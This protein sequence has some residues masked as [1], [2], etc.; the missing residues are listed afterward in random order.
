M[1][2]MESMKKN[3][4]T[5]WVF[6]PVDVHELTGKLG[7]AVNFIKLFKTIQGK[8]FR[9]NGKRIAYRPNWC[10]LQLL[11]FDCGSLSSSLVGGSSTFGADE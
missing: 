6:S 5:T 11:S 4:E 7:I 9:T 8:P 2:S 3:G 1:R 10:N